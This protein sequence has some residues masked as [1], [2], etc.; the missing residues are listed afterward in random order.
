MHQILLQR[1]W[2]GGQ[3][4][5]TTLK[6]ESDINTVGEKYCALDYSIHI[7][8]FIN[9]YL[10]YIGEILWRLDHS[11]LIIALPLPL[12]VL[13]IRHYLYELIAFDRKPPA[14]EEKLCAKSESKYNCIS[15]YVL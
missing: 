12:P 9:A 11:R 8:Q 3:K 1:T 6:G 4:G 14:E 2:S 7:I 5:E 10:L 15:S 13:Y